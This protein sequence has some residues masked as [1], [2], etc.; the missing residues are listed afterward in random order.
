MFPGKTII[1]DLFADN[2][3]PRSLNQGISLV[4]DVCKQSIFADLGEILTNFDVFGL[5][6]GLKLQIPNQQLMEN[7]ISVYFGWR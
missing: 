4:K 7:E 1:S 3:R 6:K 5:V 2:E